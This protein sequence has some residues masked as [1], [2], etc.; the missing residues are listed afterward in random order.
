MKESNIQNGVR[1]RLSTFQNNLLLRYTVGT[2]LT[3][4]GRPVKIGQVGV[5]DLIGI[6]S[7]VVTQADVGR[8]IGIF[9]AMETKKE[10]DG[11]SKERKENQGKFISLVN[12]L[13]G[14]A[15]IV[16][17]EDDAVDMI[18]KKWDSQPVLMAP[19]HEHR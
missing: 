1:L 3:M 9:T 16:R 10:R 4:D 13:G 18:S 12:L 6:T 7:H 19:K 11:T 2:F 17:S 15:G 5:S 14:I 8:T